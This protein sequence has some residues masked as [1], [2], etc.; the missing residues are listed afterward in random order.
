MTWAAK[1][2]DYCEACGGRIHAGSLIDW[3]EDQSGCVVHAECGDFPREETADVCPTCW[4]TSCDC[5][6]NGAR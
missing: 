3:S 1:F 2:D 5:D 4:L 6:R